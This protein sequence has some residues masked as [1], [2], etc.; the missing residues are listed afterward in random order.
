MI[1]CGMLAKE[2]ASMD[3]ERQLLPDDIDSPSSEQRL[4]NIVLFHDESIFNSNEDESVQWG[5]KDQYFVHPKSKGAGIMVA[6]YIEEL[7]IFAVD[8]EAI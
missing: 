1:V 6:D 8:H 5:M 4:N 2:H 7:R 3:D